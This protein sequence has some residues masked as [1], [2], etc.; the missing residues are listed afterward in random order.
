M[1]HEV[2]DVVCAAAQRLLELPPG[3]P[4]EPVQGHGALILEL[5]ERLVHPLLLTLHIQGR[6]AAGT[7]D[8]PQNAER[9][10]DAERFDRLR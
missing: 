3:L 6:R 9:G 2:K 7:G 5:P 1:A 8:H 10:I 4:G